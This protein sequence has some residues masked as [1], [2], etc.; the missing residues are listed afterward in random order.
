MHFKIDDEEHL[1]SSVNGS[2]SPN[3]ATATLKLA[4]LFTVLL[5]IGINLAHIIY[6]PP[7]SLIKFLQWKYPEVTFHFPP[8]SFSHRKVISLTIDDS[9]S[10][11][12]AKIL[13]LLHKFNAK[14]T[15]FVIG[16]QIA[17]YPH[18]V[19][20]IIDEGHEI[21]IHGWSD[22]AS[23]SL[24]L[25]ELVRQIREMEQLLPKNFHSSKWFR[26]GSGWFSKPMISMLRTMD[27]QIV[28]GSIY[29]HDPQIPFPRINAAHVL[30]LIRPGAII[31]MHDRRPYSSRQLELILSG[32][33][34]DDWTV[35]TLSATQQSMKATTI[36]SDR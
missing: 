19:Q 27:Y 24:P 17:E 28:L 7:Y 32:L 10:S 23:Y 1:L 18:V 25:P 26:P 29:P 20:R 13:D 33:A 21:G 3:G 34:T 35:Q 14:A 4:V 8:P 6:K 9:P 12:T 36:V 30:S 22:E 31:I 11:E 15:F 2:T 5:I 16:E